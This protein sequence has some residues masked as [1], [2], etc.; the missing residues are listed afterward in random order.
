MGLIALNSICSSIVSSLAQPQHC[1]F[2][3][4][5]LVLF[6]LFHQFF[7]EEKWTVGRE[8]IFTLIIITTIACFN[9][10]AAKIMYGDSLSLTRWFRMI[11]YTGIIG[12]APATVSILLNQTRLL[13]KYR[14]EADKLNLQ[15]P[16]HIK[17]NVGVEIMELQEVVLPIEQLD[18]KIT[19][20]FVT[21]E[22]ENEK[23]N[24]TILAA[25]FLAATSAANYVKVYYV[26]NERPVTAILR[27]T[28]K[29][30]AENTAGFPSFYRCH[31]TALVNLAAVQNVVGTAQGYRLQLAFL[32]D[33]IPVSRNLNKEVKERLAAIQNP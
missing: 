26:K 1:L 7:K 20:D 19:A 24:L 16:H 4:I 5:F 12:I 25:N 6:P 9:V 17:E 30:V 31:R 8:I 18:E 27:T 3:L 2:A 21:I 14:K 11:F 22:A 23:E 32:Q 10:L 33:E 29:K 28:L 13:K 15:L